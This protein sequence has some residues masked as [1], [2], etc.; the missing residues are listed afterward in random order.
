MN[1][2]NIKEVEY[3]SLECL[4]NSDAK[5]PYCGYDNFIESEDYGGQDDEEIEECGEC[6]KYFVH[7]IDYEITFTS[8]PYENHYLDKRKSV[9]KQLK[10]CNELL[11]KAKKEKSDDAEY[12][13]AIV[14]H[15]ARELADLENEAKQ[16]LGVD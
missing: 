5:C 10:Y 4:A 11:N 7:Q 13:S 16:Y 3:D 8:Q 15:K 1:L 2:D 9:E 6:G 12:Y 14:R